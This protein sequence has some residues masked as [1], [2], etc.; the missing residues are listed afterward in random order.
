MHSLSDLFNNPFTFS[1]STR[2]KTSQVY[3]IF[4]YLFQGWGIFCAT[5]SARYSQELAD[6]AADM[7]RGQ[8]PGAMVSGVQMAVSALGII[9]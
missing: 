3:L 2:H 8:G 4:I 7:V 9:H 5:A 6:Q 1:N